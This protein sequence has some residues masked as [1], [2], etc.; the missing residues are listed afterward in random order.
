MYCANCG[1]PVAPGLSF[2][3]R[4]GNSLKERNEPSHTGGITA[5]LIAISLIG[6]VGMGIMLGGAL[7]LKKESL[8]SDIVGFFM[9]FT[10]LIV[11]VIEIM[12]VRQ[13]SR[14]TAPEQKRQS[15]I[16]EKATPLELP[17]LRVASLG[18]P[19]QSVT[20]NT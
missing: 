9:L 7:A 5:F 14:L 8:G 19:L 20:E 17:P 10:L 16:V 6:I 15:V 3:N 1:T 13:L 11:G 18:E 2:C 12:L 4:C